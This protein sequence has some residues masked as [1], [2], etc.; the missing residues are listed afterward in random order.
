MSGT[1]KAGIKKWKVTESGVSNME[2][3]VNSDHSLFDTEDFNTYNLELKSI[4]E[5]NVVIAWISA[6]Q[7][8]CD[9]IFIFDDEGTD[10]VIDLNLGRIGGVEFSSLDDYIIY[11]SCSDAGIVAVNYHTEQITEY[12]TSDNEYD[13]TYLQTA[14]DGHIYG[15]RFN[16]T[17]LHSQLGRINM[18]TGDFEDEQFVFPEQFQ[19]VGTFKDFGTDRYY[20]LPENDKKYPLQVTVD[21]EYVTCPGGNDGSAT[22]SVTGGEE[23]FIYT[24]YKFQND[25]WVLLPQYT[26]ETATGLSEGTY[27]CVV[28]DALGRINEVIFEIVVRP[29]LYTVHDFVEVEENTVWTTDERYEF[30]FKVKSGYRLTLSG[31]NLQFGEEA[32]IIVE[33]GAD[34]IVDNTVLTNI[35]ECDNKWHGI[36]VWGDV[37]MYQ[38]IY[39]DVRYQGYIELI[40]NSS[41]ENAEVGIATYKKLWNGQEWD[42]DWSTAGGI[43]QSKNSNFINNTKSVHFIPYR[44]YLPVNPELTMDNLSYFKIDTFLINT[45]YIYTE[46]FYKHADVH[47]VRDI[48]FKG[49]C[50]LNN[51]DENTQ[52][53]ATVNMGIGAYSA[54]IEVT[55]FCNMEPPNITNPCDPDFLIISSFSGF[56]SGIEAFEVSEQ[57]T[58]YYTV[59]EALFTN[60]II[61]ILNS[62]VDY[63]TIINN[64]FQVGYSELTDAYDD[65]SGVP[66]GIGI[67]MKDAMGFAVEDN[68][69]TKYTPAPIGTY[70]G[71]R[72]L[73]CPSDHDIIYRNSFDGLSYGNYAQGTNRKNPGVDQ[74]GVEYQCNTN[75]NNEVDFIVT[76]FEEVDDGMIRTDHGT[77]EY[78][79]ANTFTPNA[80]WHIRNEGTQTID[81]FYCETCPNEEP[82]FVYYLD[83]IYFHAYIS[84]NPYNCPDHYGGGGTVG[85]TSSERLQKES[86]YA[87][88]LAD[89]N[90]VEPLYQS[91]IDGGDTEAELDDIES[92]EPDDMWDLRDQLLGD[93]PHLSQE[94]LRE[95]SDRTDVFPDDVLLEILS[96]N[97]DELKEDTLLKYLEQKEDPLPDYMIE[98]LRQTAPEVS[99]KTVLERDMARYY[100]GR[101]QAAQD[102]IRS[103]LSDTALDMT[104]YRNWLDNLGGINADKQIISSYLNENDTASAL[105]LLNM[106]PSLYDLQGDELN[107]FYDYKNLVLMQ[108][109]WRINNKTIFQLDS[110]DIDSL[111]FY[112]NYS[113]GSAKTIARNILN[114]AYNYD[115]CDCLNQYDSSYYKTSHPPIINGSSRESGLDI[116]AEP[117]PADSWTVFKY[118]LIGEES[119]GYIIISDVS[120]KKITEFKVNGKTSQQLWDTRSIKPGIYFY[121]L[122]SNGFSKTGKIVV[123]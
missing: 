8:S 111:E 40:N 26:N 37:N 2:I 44:N 95:M 57:Y 23:P 79:S 80:D 47:G 4:D 1:L 25:G 41:V 74:Q 62:G 78:A 45:D 87:E 35:I 19:C 121:T 43:I 39:N 20:T 101:C 104:D 88:N 107:D 34:L 68:S 83:P 54:G 93:S 58:N 42:V 7:Q 59:E 123:N 64:I 76:F 6:D 61:G 98:I 86:D 46:T 100:A 5:D 3:I 112:A 113:N 28:E 94:V 75:T 96:S 48:D 77:E 9:K 119:V 56:H 38:Y 21:T 91:L 22:V 97:P 69:F 30:G 31:C 84:T 105:S 65:C 12:L 15:T 51:T 114:Y 14:P 33:Q 50:F 27:K 89:Y 92:A 115:F 17:T 66:Y 72:V 116:W 55:S 73:N 36:E 70:T 29:D 82:I 67:D 122:T 10:K 106:M 85:L 63:A 109:N 71:I 81:W 53:I 32:K 60:N 99:Y 118:T 110:T 90:S 49:C 18:G 52:G 120:G 24:W 11:A 13:Q 103:I 117:N 16:H 108:I 102:I